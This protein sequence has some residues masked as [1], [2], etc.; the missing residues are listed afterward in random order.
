MPC[1]LP[2]TTSTVW[3]PG[4]WPP[5]ATLSKVPEPPWD[6]S[7]TKPHT[8]CKDDIYRI[9]LH[10]SFSTWHESHWAPLG[11][12]ILGERLPRGAESWHRSV[13]PALGASP[14]SDLSVTDQK[15]L[16]ENL[17]TLYCLSE[18]LRMLSYTFWKGCLLP[19]YAKRSSFYIL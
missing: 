1:R 16:G 14:P 3:P 2:Y 4:G 5:P 15:Q 9:S 10:T 12:H 17:E 11:R 13:N 8:V 6:P 18:D 19:L 7:A